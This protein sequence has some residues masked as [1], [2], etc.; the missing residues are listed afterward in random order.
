MAVR[1]LVQFQFEGVHV[2]AFVALVI[3]FDMT[4]IDVVG[5]LDFFCYIRSVLEA[6]VNETA[7]LRS[8][9]GVVVNVEEMKITTNCIDVIGQTSFCDCEFHMGPDSRP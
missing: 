1:T 9:R 5:A 2:V 4:E 7:I 3:F 6:T 8:S